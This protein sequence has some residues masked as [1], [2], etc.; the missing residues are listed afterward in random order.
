MEHIMVAYLRLA[1]AFV[2]VAL[3]DGFVA[4]YLVSQPDDMS[5]GLGIGAVILTLPIAFWLVKKP[6]QNMMEK[7][8]D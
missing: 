3:L 8:D 4:P 2:L 1:T 5:V 6:I 7:M